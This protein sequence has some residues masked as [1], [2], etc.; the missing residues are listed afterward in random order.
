MSTKKPNRLILRARRLAY[1]AALA[2]M[3]WS[4]VLVVAK[5]WAWLNGDSTAMLGSMM[6]SAMDLVVSTTNFLALRYAFRPA[7]DSH[8]H[9]HGKAEGVAALMQAAIIGGAA[10][11]V[12]LE[13]IRQIF[14]PVEIGAISSSIVV[15]LIASLGTFALTRYQSFVAKKT[16]S[17]AIEADSAHYTSDLI[18]NGG[19][20]LSL[21]VVNQ[22]G[23]TWFDPLAGMAV[24]AWLMW[25]A[26]DIALKAWDM[27]LDR[28]ITD[29]TRQTIIDIITTSNGIAS[30]H[31]LR[32]TK[33][34]TALMV[35]F[36]VEV[37]PNM[38]VAESHD[39]VRKI[40]QSIM[41]ATRRDYTRTEVMIHVDP[42][43]DA[44]DSRHKKLEAYHAH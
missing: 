41:R 14:N 11:F 1:S 19:I 36:D 15:M 43:G 8:R 35:S 33:S 21:L 30:M 24:A 38:T 39:V 13:A 16:G 9:G 17:L 10:T 5:G 2:A 31:D 12:L 37:D 26:R 44:T 3:A 25:Q 29:D 20:I 32:M 28:E 23:W 34:G 40:E 27:L 6:D 42:I 22:T 7:D 4:F 18:A